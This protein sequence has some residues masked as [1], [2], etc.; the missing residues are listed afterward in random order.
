MP[1]V[2][3]NMLM[4][5]RASIRVVCSSAIIEPIDIELDGI[6]SQDFQHGADA[7]GADGDADACASVR[8][9]SRAGSSAHIRKMPSLRMVSKTKLG[10][11]AQTQHAQEPLGPSWEVA[12]VRWIIRLRDELEQRANRSGGRADPI[13]IHE[14]RVFRLPCPR[15]LCSRAALIIRIEDTLLLRF[16][17]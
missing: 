7:L 10:E 3:P 11:R 8:A 9:R 13:P 16:Q 14:K 12:R 4:P 5:R 2:R 6:Q 17:A 1:N 15:R